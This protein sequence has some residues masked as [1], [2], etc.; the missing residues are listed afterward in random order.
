[1]D[2]IRAQSAPFSQGDHEWDAY[3]D[4]S[5]ND[6]HKQGKTGQHPAEQNRVQG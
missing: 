3:T 6:V 1:M 2:I 4:G 5:K